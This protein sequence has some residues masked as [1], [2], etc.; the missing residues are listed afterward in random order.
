MR[1]VID[2]VVAE[3]VFRVAVACDARR[4]DSY[5]A[6]RRWWPGY[7]A[8]PHLW[9]RAAEIWLERQCGVREVAREGTPT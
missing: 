7:S 2:L 4:A 5:H 8:A 1:A 6:R 3:A 9:A